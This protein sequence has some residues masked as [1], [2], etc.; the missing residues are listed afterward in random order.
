M[1]GKFAVWRSKSAGPFVPATGWPIGLPW[2]DL[3]TSN[4][5]GETRFK[6]HLLGE[7]KVPAGGRVLDV[8][9]GTGTLA[10]RLKQLRPDVDIVGL[11]PDSRILA[12]ARM[13]PGATEICWQLGD[14]C[15]LPFS[16]HTFDC[17]FCTLVL[18]HLR[19]EQTCQALA[20]I[21]R[22]LKPGSSLLLADYGAPASALARVQFLP[23]RLIDG[24]A[25][26]RCNVQGDLPHLLDAAGFES[27]T[28]SL[29]MPTSLGTLRC[30]RAQT[31]ARQH[32]TR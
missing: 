31:A 11:D 29:V 20:E 27:I 17:A 28:Q 19:T 25:Q 7:C 2:Y 4:L 30:Y 3:L 18:H 26:T 10:L 13:K 32:P 15:K 8:G 22:V 5:T 12:Q 16:S 14:A 24:W 1:I 6:G 23:V 9:C 21:Q